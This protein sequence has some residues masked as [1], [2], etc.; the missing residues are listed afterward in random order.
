[1]AL[2]IQFVIAAAAMGIACIGHAWP[3]ALLFSLQMFHVAHH[4]DN[5]L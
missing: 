2:K 5:S 4:L 3:L 1:M